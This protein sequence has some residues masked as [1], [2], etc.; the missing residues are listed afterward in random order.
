MSYSFI[1]SS[2][3][4]YFSKFNLFLVISSSQKSNNFNSRRH[5]G[6]AWEI[7]WQNK[8]FLS[9]IN[10]YS[11]KFSHKISHFKFFSKKSMNRSLKIFGALLEIVWRKWINNTNLFQ[12]RRIQERTEIQIHINI[13]S[14]L[15]RNS[16][17]LKSNIY[18]VVKNSTLPIIQKFK[19]KIIA[20]YEFY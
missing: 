4:N 13:L 14:K 1:N 3:S 6:E 7:K 11:F 9:S 20:K 2:L 15:S 18:W 5:Y 17:N 12:L 8:L 16:Y 19:I 10:S